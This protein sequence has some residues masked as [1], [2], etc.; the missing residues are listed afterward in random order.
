M[1]LGRRECVLRLL[2]QREERLSLLPEEAF[3][4]FRIDGVAS[5]EEVLDCRPCRACAPCA[6]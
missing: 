5:A 1:R 6:C 3:L 2:P 4:L